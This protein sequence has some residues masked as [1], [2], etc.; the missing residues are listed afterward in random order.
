LTLHLPQPTSI[1]GC[2]DA[3][4]TGLKAESQQP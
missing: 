3:P 4:A 2:F 1:R